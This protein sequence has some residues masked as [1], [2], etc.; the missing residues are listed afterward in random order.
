MKHVNHLIQARP[1]FGCVNGEAEFIDGFG[2]FIQKT[3]LIIGK[4]VNNGKLIRRRIVDSDFGPT[5]LN[6]PLAVKRHA[7]ILGENLFN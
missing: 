2:Y 4:H 7:L 5:L 1:D 6:W 3:R